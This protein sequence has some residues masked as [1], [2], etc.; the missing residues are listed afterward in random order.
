MGRTR[1][2][3]LN[4]S[5]Y[6]LAQKQGTRVVKADRNFSW[7]VVCRTLWPSKTHTPKKPTPPGERDDWTRTSLPRPAFR[8]QEG[9]SAKEAPERGLAGRRRGRWW[10][11]RSDP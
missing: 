10:R 1:L 3:C 8:R 4:F 6:I 5:P 9:V 11:G 2:A 7:A